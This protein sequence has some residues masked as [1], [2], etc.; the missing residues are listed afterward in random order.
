MESAVGSLAVAEARKVLG[1]DVDA[2]VSPMTEKEMLLLHINIV[3]V[4]K[5]VSPQDMRQLVDRIAAGIEKTVELQ[6]QAPRE[7]QLADL[8]RK[9]ELLSKR[10]REMDD[11]TESGRQEL[12]KITGQTDVSPEALHAAMSKM[13]QERQ[14][15][16]IDL[17]A[18]EAR[19]N[20]LQRTIAEQSKDVMDRVQEDP[21]A[22][23]L[24]T[25]VK[26]R[27]QQ[28]EHLK[29]QFAAGTAPSSEVSAAAVALAEA[30][31][32]LLERQELVR[33]RAG[34]DMLAAWNRELLNLSIDR[35]EKTVRN[36]YIDKRLAAFRDVD[37]LLERIALEQEGRQSLRRELFD[38]QKQIGAIEAQPKPTVT[39]D[40]VKD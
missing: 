14:A 38:V 34:G 31:A 35:A 20:A 7:R 30:K 33:T 15:L 29:A 22:N 26:V 10:L 4:T 1:P 2:E 17:V 6:G 12:R 40:Q 3:Q 37:P 19:R 5:E 16:Q 32:K 39:V 25:V 8:K 36:D 18:M 23:E 9:F 27:T 24:Q 28:L 21:I 13:D 11:A